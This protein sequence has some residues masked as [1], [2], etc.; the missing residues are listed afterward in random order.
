[1]TIANSGTTQF[2]IALY[3]DVT[4]LSSPAQ[5]VS[6]ESIQ[7]SLAQSIREFASGIDGGDQFVVEGVRIA[8]H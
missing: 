7:L 6:A 8:P 1:M 3:L 5:Y 4:N 2:A